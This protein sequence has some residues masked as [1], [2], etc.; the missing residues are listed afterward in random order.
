MSEFRSHYSTCFPARER[1]K[2]RKSEIKLSY[3][4]EKICKDYLSP[5]VL[6][7]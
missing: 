4:F 5:T 2:D 6:A 3:M 1:Q 7:V